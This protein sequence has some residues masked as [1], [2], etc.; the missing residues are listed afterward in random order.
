MS[1]QVGFVGRGVGR[2][3]G[4]GGTGG[5][6]AAK[7]A[8]DVIGL[9]ERGGLREAC[10][11]L[12]SS[13]EGRLKVSSSCEAGLRKRSSGGRNRRARNARKGAK[14]RAISS[15]GWSPTLAGRNHASVF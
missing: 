14:A 10:H 8:R 1:L 11:D 15:H 9:S 13:G 3:V 4:E 2:H 7:A 5:G 6:K 12:S